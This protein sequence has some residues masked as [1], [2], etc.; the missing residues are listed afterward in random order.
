ME[1]QDP[2]FCESLLKKMNEH[3]WLE[4]IQSIHRDFQ[5]AGVTSNAL[6]KTSRD[7]LNYVLSLLKNEPPLLPDLS[8]TQWRE[9]LSLFKPHS[10]SPI[11]YQRLSVLP[12][13]LQPPKEIVNQLRIT[14]LNMRAQCFPI[15]KQIGEIAAAFGQRGIRVL[16]LKG[17]A[18][19]WSV[20]PDPVLRPFADIDILVLPENVG[21]ARE[22]LESLGYKCP[23]KKFEI[24]RESLWEEIFFHTNIKEDRLIIELHWDLHRFSA[25]KNDF[26]LSELFSRSRKVK[27]PSFFIETL[28][29]VDS[30]NYSALHMFFNHTHEIRLNWIY[31]IALIAKQLKVPDDWRMLQQRSVSWNARIAAEQALKMAELWSDF[32]IPEAFGDFSLWPQPSAVEITSWHNVKSKDKFLFSMLKL[33]MP[34]NLNFFEKLHFFYR[35][36]FPP[37]LHI[38]KSY[39]GRFL[40]FLYVKYWLKWFRRI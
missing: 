2:D 23:V 21:P 5:L 16:F 33:R 8:L 24:L 30:L 22:I 40:P 9:L 31:D 12:H 4:K 20:Y 6:L 14:F 36:L 32:K 35:F 7:S 27:A 11:L 34:Q 15:E 3:D 17:A 37:V 1:K 10:I 26:S 19:A 29:L 28:D 18:L 25:I 39:P 38:R 13:E